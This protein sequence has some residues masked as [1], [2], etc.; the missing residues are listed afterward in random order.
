MEK[1]QMIQTV[2]KIQETKQEE[3][4]RGSGCLTLIAI[5]I[6]LAAVGFHLYRVWELD[7]ENSELYMQIYDLQYQLEQ[8]QSSPLHTLDFTEAYPVAA[9]TSEE[10]DIP[11][12]WE[13]LEN[14]VDLLNRLTHPEM[15]SYEEYCKLFYRVSDETI[16]TYYD[17]GLSELYC[18]YNDPTLVSMF[19][20]EGY[21]FLEYAVTNRNGYSENIPMV[22]HYTEGRFYYTFADA[23]LMHLEE[24]AF[25]EKAEEKL[26]ES[27]ARY[28]LTK[29]QGGNTISCGDISTVARNVRQDVIVNSTLYAYQTETGDATVALW[30]ANGTDQDC[31]IRS[32]QVRI[33]GLG[34]IIC[35]ASYELPETIVVPKR[36]GKL[37]LLTVPADQI[38]TGTASWGDYAFLAVDYS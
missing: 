3:S 31:I 6:I 20:Y 32:A 18:P 13:T 7:A 10:Q 15:Q 17:G 4:R 8:M 5:F 27:Y 34:E 28:L 29:A 25:R 37:V 14:A 1:Q 11:M 24:I 26:G 35:N 33:M 22:T 16:R 30:I 19:P 2:D 36:E 9:E 12:T 23:R 38:L 21:C